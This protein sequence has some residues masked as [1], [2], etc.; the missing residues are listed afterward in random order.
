MKKRHL[1]TMT[2]AVASLLVA[3]VVSVPTANAAT[4]TLQDVLN[5]GKLIVGTGSGNPPF[6]FLDTSGKLV[7]MDI[8]IAKAIAKGLFN[9]ETKVEFV[10]QASDSRIPNVV[11]GK[12]D[13]TCQF[14]TV[15]ATRAQ[16]VAFTNPYYREGVGLLMK[17][18]G[19]YK[20]FAALLKAGKTAKIS[21]L[22]NVTADAYVHAALPNATV[23]QYAE[24][25]LI[26]TAL[27]AGRVDA[28]ASDQSAIAWLVASNP[29]KYV[30]S[31]Y[32]WMPQTYSCAVKQGDQ[33]WLN[34]VNQ[35]LNEAMTGVDFDA[36]AA[37]FK[38]WFGV[39]LPPPK[40]GFPR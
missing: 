3:T 24:T 8:D 12:V 9:D 37:S 19:K 7:G 29:T 27:D 10:Q 1:A 25:A 30:D 23:L 21:I 15:T 18:G 14:M 2:V 35:V 11:S 34:F 33:V 26:Y 6:H 20:D 31:G 16:Q 28:A 32:G 17:K 5:R 36:Y 22:Q 4:G 39:T 13:I 40:I 38:K